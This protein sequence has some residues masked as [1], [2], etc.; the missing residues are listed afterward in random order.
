MTALNIACTQHYFTSLVYPVFEE[1]SCSFLSFWIFS[2]KS[3]ALPITGMQNYFLCT[4]ITSIASAQHFARKLC[5]VT[6][7]QQDSKTLGKCENCPKCLSNIFYTQ[8]KP[9][10]VRKRL[11]AWRTVV[12]R[13]M[14]CV[15][16]YDMC[17]FS[18]GKEAIPFSSHHQLRRI[19]F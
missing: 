9:G 1:S 11:P 3:K 4:H 13:R 15:L 6:G 10:K 8:S 12:P 5:A 16:L 7:L 18:S 17:H 14:L 2:S 19:V